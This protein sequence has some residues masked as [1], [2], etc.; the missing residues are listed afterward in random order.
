[1]EIRRFASDPPYKAADVRMLRQSFTIRGKARQLTVGE[2]RVDGAV[3]DGMHRHALTP[4]PAFGLRMMP[5]NP[6]AKH[7][8]AKPTGR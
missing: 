7:S 2:R 8:A 4:S 5:F 3:A 1:M 6:P